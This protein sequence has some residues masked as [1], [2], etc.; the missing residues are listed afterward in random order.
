[1]VTVMIWLQSGVLVETS[2]EGVVMVGDKVEVDVDGSVRRYFGDLRNVVR[3]VG[4][5]TGVEYP[6]GCLLVD[7]EVLL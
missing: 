4:V 2:C 6:D 1:M 3:H 7:G 5:V